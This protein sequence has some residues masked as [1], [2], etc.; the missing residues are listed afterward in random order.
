[1]RILF[2]HLG[3]TPGGATQSL[4]ILVQELHSLGEE[5]YLIVPSISDRV[6]MESLSVHCK[7]VAVINV[8]QF[9][10]NQAGHSSLRAI[11]RE[12]FYY[13]CNRRRL[14]D[15]V[16]DHKIDLVH[17][18]STVLAHLLRY[19]KV[20]DVHTCVHVR[21]L[22][23]SHHDPFGL[24]RMLI[25]QIRR[26]ADQIICISENETAPFSDMMNVSVIHNS[27]DG[28]SAPENPHYSGV[29]KSINVFMMAD[30][31]RSKGHLQFLLA[32]R[33]FLDNYPGIAEKCNFLISGVR[34]REGHGILARIKGTVI[35]NFYDEFAELMAT[36]RLTDVVR[37]KPPTPDVRRELA[38][39][40]VLVRPSLAGDPWGRDIIEAMA[41]GKAV[42]ATGKYSKFVR[43]GYN[44][45]LVD[46]N[47][48]EAIAHALA[49]IAHDDAKLAQYSTNSQALALLL[50]DPHVNTRKV[51]AV[52]QRMIST[53][54]IVQTEQHAPD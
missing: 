16:R 46:V 36:L 53:Y 26:F 37:I 7:K 41:A 43:P 42:I 5:V 1:M 11:V 52:Y 8:G 32:I 6:L 9:H 39:A 27:F 12:G 2:V 25:R 44:G 40:S 13:W 31:H 47:N 51:L 33:H 17:L 22:L 18:N 23:A 45:I 14:R 50:F 48:P 24:G 20:T 28:R 19:L 30:F 15:F 38:W 3:V 29:P 34:K 10:S 54:G 21:E 4:R 35:R 49:E